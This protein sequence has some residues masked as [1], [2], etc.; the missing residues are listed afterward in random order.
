MSTSSSEFLL[1]YP[2]YSEYVPSGFVPQ[3]LKVGLTSCP[4][5]YRICA[6]TRTAPATNRRAIEPATAQRRYGLIPMFLSSARAAQCL[7]LRFS[8]VRL[9]FEILV[10]HVIP[11]DPRRSH[12]ID[13]PLSPCDLGVRIRVEF[14]RGRVVMPRNGMQNSPCRQQRCC[15]VVVDIVDVPVEIEPGAGQHLALSGG[16]NGLQ[17]LCLSAVM[18]VG[19]E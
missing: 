18:H 12:F 7:P 16:V 15:V 6:T 4:L 13:R 8:R 1:K 11:A 9:F 5:A 3:P 2:K 17:A 14:V 19:L 10:G